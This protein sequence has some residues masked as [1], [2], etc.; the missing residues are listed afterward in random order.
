MKK[1]VA[2]R[3]V[4]EGTVTIELNNYT[5]FKGT[6]TVY[7]TSHEEAADVNPP[8]EFVSTLDDEYTR[9]WKIPVGPGTTWKATYQGNGGGNLDI[10]GVEEGKLVVVDIN[11]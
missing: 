10:R 9:V 2:K 7:E 6:V 5:D 3:R 11:A 4:K 8:P 1:L